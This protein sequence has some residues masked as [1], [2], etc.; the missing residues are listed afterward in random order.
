MCQFYP[1]ML[2]GSFPGGTESFSLILPS[3]PC[4]D[5]S[6]SPCFL[7]SDLAWEMASACV[8][9]L[10]DAL[11]ASSLL[12]THVPSERRKTERLLM[13][14]TCMF[15]LWC[16]SVGILRICTTYVKEALSLE[17]AL[18]LIFS[19]VS[20]PHASR[21]V[22]KFPGSFLR[23]P[24]AYGVDKADGVFS[25]IPSMRDGNAFE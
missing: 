8:S 3:T 10:D 15:L 9:C 13:A 5:N 16:S 18:H 11:L 21:I 2:G 14:T 4:I 20:N 17:R 25:P 24:S 1:G 7:R 23:S 12:L 22:S 6:P 19:V